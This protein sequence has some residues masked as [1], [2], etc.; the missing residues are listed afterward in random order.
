MADK[1]VPAFLT[2]SILG[3][4]YSPKVDGWEQDIRVSFESFET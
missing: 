3:R 2:D 4:R 1:K